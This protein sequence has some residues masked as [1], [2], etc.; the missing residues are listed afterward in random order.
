MLR[1]LIAKLN[2]FLDRL[3][4]E[5]PTV[6]LRK[7]LV[8]SL[9]V[10]AILILIVFINRAYGSLSSSESMVLAVFGVSAL[11]IFLFPESKLYSPLII[12]EANLLATSIAFVCVYLFSNLVIG[13]IFVILSTILGLYFLACMYPPALFL[14]I[15]LFIAKVDSLEFAFYPVF[16]D[17]LILALASYLNRQYLKR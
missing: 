4:P 17:S 15:V 3:A 13:I 8:I 9:G 7:A 14:A 11:C 2:S 1:K 6:P 16:V 10:G 5:Q 12:L